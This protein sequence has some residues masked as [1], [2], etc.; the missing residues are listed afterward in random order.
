MNRGESL[1]RNPGEGGRGLR[2]LARAV[3]PRPAIPYIHQL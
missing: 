2:G 1:L 3:G